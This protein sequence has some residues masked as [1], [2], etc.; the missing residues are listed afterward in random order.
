LKTLLLGF[1]HFRVKLDL[2][3][4]D[5]RW[6]PYGP[7]QRSHVVV[8]SFLRLSCALHRSHVVIIVG[9]PFE[10]V[11]ARFCS[12]PCQNSTYISMTLVVHHMGPLQRSHVPDTSSPRLSRAL[13]YPT[14]CHHC[15]GLFGDVTARFCSFPC[16]NSTY[17]LTTLAG[18]HMGPLQRSHVVVTFFL[19]LS[20]MCSRC[21]HHSHVVIIARA[22]FEDITDR[23][24]S[25]PCPRSTF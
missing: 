6:S 4:D 7:Q 3:F 24:C 10:D 9:V 19:R 18:H 15:G 1:A 2:H 16:Q 25:L 23:F 12:L 13:H 14:R 5:A 21:M 11:T 17:I 22:F 8:T 20:Y